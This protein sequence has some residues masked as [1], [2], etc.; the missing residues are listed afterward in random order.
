M[1]S[2]DVALTIF[3]TTIMIL[4]LVTGVIITF[5]LS[6]RRNAR[7]ELQIVQIQR[8]YEKELRKVQ[9]EV[10]EQ[11]LVNV[12]RELHDNIGQLLTYMNMQLEQYKYIGNTSRELLESMGTTLTATMQ[13]VQRLGKS[14]NSDLFESQGLIN[15]IQQEVIRLRQLNNYEVDWSHDLEPQLDK[16][17]KVITFRIFQEILNNIMKHSGSTRILISLRG[18]GKFCMKVQDNGK[19]FDYNEMVESGKGSGLKNMVKRA[20]LAKLTCNIQSIIGKGTTF[21]LETI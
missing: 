17:Q 16:D 19:G 11:V 4:L 6:N 10:Q 14:L 18:A 2:N 13:E 5:I 1:G 9:F 21:T 7:Q 15:T 20:E 12:G 8:D 3:V